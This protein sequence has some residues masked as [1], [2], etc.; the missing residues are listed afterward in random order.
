MHSA[1]APSE[2]AKAR[3]GCGG[4]SKKGDIAIIG[5]SGRFPGAENVE[6]LWKNLLDK[7]NSI[8]RWT[9]EETRPEH[10]RRNCARTTPTMS[11]P[12]V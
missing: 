10:S 8:S 4:G 5:M 7:K 6:Q 9:K 2:M 3:K 1:I 12:V 11:R